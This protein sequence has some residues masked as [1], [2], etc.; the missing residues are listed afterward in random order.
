MRIAEASIDEKGNAIGGVS[1]DQT[2]KEV[3]VG[4]WYP[5]NWGQVIRCKDKTKA[6]IIAKAAET[7][8]NNDCIGY[9]QGGRLSLYNEIKK[10]GF[11][12]Y[13]KL[14]VK[15]ETDCSAF[16]AVCCNIAGIKIDPSVVCHTLDE[17]CKKSGEFEILTDLKYLIGTDYLQVGDIIN[18]PWYHVVVALDNGSK[19]QS[20]S[21]KTEKTKVK[22][23]KIDTKTDQS[24][25]VVKDNDNLSLIASKFKTTVSNLVKINKIKNPNLIKTGQKIKL[26]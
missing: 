3:H 7:L 21:D 14:N 26:K 10:I 25:Y 18:K 17:A 19:T 4:N 9:D 6:K 20:A 16:T 22:P 8:A 5:Y 13:E 12:N 24:V 1:G 23:T 2:K 11:N 15:C